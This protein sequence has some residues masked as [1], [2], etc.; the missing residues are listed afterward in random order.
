M[1]L[2][3]PIFRDIYVISKQWLKVTGWAI[4]IIFETKSKLLSEF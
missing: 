4:M 2:K 1:D 3:R